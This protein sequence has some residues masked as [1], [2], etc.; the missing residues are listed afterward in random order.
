MAYQ[1]THDPIAKVFNLCFVNHEPVNKRGVT[2][3]EAELTS[4]LI[5]EIGEYHCGQIITGATAF[6]ADYFYND[7]GIPSTPR[8]FSCWRPENMTYQVRVDLIPYDQSDLGML[9]L[10][11]SDRVLNTVIHQGGPAE[12]RLIMGRGLVPVTTLYPSD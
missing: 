9:T 6:V 8:L 3:L 11:V 12:F 1:E 5:R 2:I 7:M 4:E 10:Q